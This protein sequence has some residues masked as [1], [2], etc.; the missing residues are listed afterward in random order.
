M[1]HLKSFPI[2]AEV[3]SLNFPT[4]SLVESYSLSRFGSVHDG[5]YILTDSAVLSSKFMI[6]GGVGSN[7]E[8][9]SDILEFN[10]DIM[11]IL[12]DGS[13]SFY[14]FLFRPIK[15]L[16]STSF[17]VHCENSS[18]FFKV[19]A[20]S[21]FEKM[22]IDEDTSISFFLKKYGLADQKG[23]LKLDIEGSEWSILNDILLNISNFN[24]ICIEF[25]FISSHKERLEEFIQNLITNNF[26]V[27]SY[28]VNNA[29]KFNTENECPEIL[30][31]TFVQNC[32]LDDKKLLQRRSNDE[33]NIIFNF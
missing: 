24:A 2:V 25:H 32:F 18:R 28:S 33:S 19:K 23:I 31:I 26:R 5:G 21:K 30:E 20:K 6:S 27:L 17:F 15:Y 29:V 10:S 3:K 16:F 9:E 8:F 11:L 1:S 4:L 14:R 7:V 12:V 13:T 22:Y